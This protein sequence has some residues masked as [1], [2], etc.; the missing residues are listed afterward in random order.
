MYQI[1]EYRLQVEELKK[2]VEAQTKSSQELEAQ[3]KI[4]MEQN[5]NNMLF[6]MIESFNAFK[7]RNETDQVISVLIGS[8]KDEFTKAYIEIRVASK[9][10]KD[11][12][13]TLFANRIK[14]TFSQIIVRQK[15]YLIFKKY[16]QF[17]Y[18]ILTLIDRN[19]EQMTGDIFTPFLLSQLNTNETIL[20]YLSNLVAPPD[21]PYYG[22]LNWNYF[23]TKDIIEMIKGENTIKLDYDDIDYAL[24][25][26]YF[27]ELKQQ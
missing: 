11:E 16:I 14:E 17:I 21:M 12:L 5:T 27:K 8:C 3:K 15:Y 18:N 20:L 7:S 10:S 9:I 22:N 1:K 2:S 19:K 23:T 6:G 4:L 25:T 13:N 26:K 24:M